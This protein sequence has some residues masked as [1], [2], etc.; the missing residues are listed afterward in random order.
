M[1]EFGDHTNRIAIEWEGTL[2]E[3]VVAAQEVGGPD[4]LLSLW[5]TKSNGR[6]EHILAAIP[7]HDSLSRENVEGWLMASE[8]PQALVHTLAERVVQMESSAPG[9]TEA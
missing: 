4:H 3:V 5:R 9:A 2:W 6:R 8:V 7:P 1:S